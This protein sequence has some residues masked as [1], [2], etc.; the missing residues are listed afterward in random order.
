MPYFWTHIWLA[1]QFYVPV[2][3]AITAYLFWTRGVR[4]K[5]YGADGMWRRIVTAAS[6]VY[7][8]IMAGFYFVGEYTSPGVGSTSYMMHGRYW[9]FAGMWLAGAGVM[10]SILGRGAARVIMTLLMLALLWWWWFVWS[11]SFL[12]F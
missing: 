6:F 5:K 7:G 11:L 10:L 1:P 4:L 12:T 8:L 2:V 3:L 9:A